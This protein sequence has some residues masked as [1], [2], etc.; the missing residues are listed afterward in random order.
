M[1]V[2]ILSN[3]QKSKNAPVSSML[4]LNSKPIIYYVISHFLKSGYDDFI[5]TIPKGNSS[6][7]EYLIKIASAE[8][9]Y[10]IDERNVYFEKISKKFRILILERECD[11]DLARTLEFASKYIGE[12]AF[13]FTYGDILPCVDIEK[14]VKFHKENG[15]VATVS[16]YQLPSLERW[17]NPGTIVFENE[18]LDYIDKNDRSFERDT[19]VK[20]AEDGEL[21]ICP[22]DVK[23][24]AI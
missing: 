15:N 24:R 6:I 18:A 19:L 21:G 1:K 13:I 11:E 22:I 5:L 4:I 17:I 2:V 9:G 16:A 8:N 14:T 10:V 3:Y 23:T 12:N 20:I 7:K